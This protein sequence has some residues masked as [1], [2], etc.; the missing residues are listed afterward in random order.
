ML[1]AGCG[2][3]PMPRIKSIDDLVTKGYVIADDDITVI[4]A[5]LAEVCSEYG[6]SI[7]N[8]KEWGGHKIV[9]GLS[10]VIDPESDVPAQPS[11]SF[12]N[13]ERL[14]EPHVELQH[15]Y[16]GKKD[17]SV[18]AVS[19]FWSLEDADYTDGLKDSV[20]VCRAKSQLVYR[21]SISPAHIAEI[22]DMLAEIREGMYTDESFWGSTHYD[23]S[24]FEPVPD[25]SG[26]EEGI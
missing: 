21:W 24:L 5:G 6:F 10:I 23:P 9:C 12:S 13:P 3:D 22:G 2:G 16:K 1:L 8:S 19:N 11:F 4:S 25:A 17:Y 7:R 18:P 26:F 15:Q 14:P 20:L